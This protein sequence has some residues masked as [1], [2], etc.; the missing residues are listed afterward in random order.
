MDLHVP[1]AHEMLAR[2][3]F[4]PEAR[5]DDLMTSWASPGGGVGPHVDGYDVF[6]VQVQGRRRWRIAPPG[7]DAFVDGL[8]LKI[9]RRFAPA[10]DWVLEP[11][12]MLYLPPLWGH[13]GV[14]VGGD[15]MTCSVGFRVPRAAELVREVLQ[16]VADDALPGVAGERLYTD[17][18]QAATTN[19]GAVPEALGGFMRAAV[20]AALRRPGVLERALGEYLSEPKPHVWFE[21]GGALPPGAAVQLDARTRALYDARRFFINGES[22]ALR[23][24]DGLLLRRLADA[25]RL[26]AADLA[27]LSAT[28]RILVEQW[29]AAGWLRV[30]V[31]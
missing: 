24:R 5:L 31:T 17:P 16:R 11:G 25:R 2:F 4:V 21:R 18:G 19:P 27:R 14:A 15:C 3:R 12:D 10:H 6:L 9:L 26:V 1:A 30:E 22:C 13:D 29:A 7:D 8:P 23:G 28:A 20:R